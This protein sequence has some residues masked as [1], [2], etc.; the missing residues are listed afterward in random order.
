MI[1]KIDMGSEP[2]WKEKLDGFVRRGQKLAV[3]V[4]DD[5]SRGPHLVTLL[6]AAGMG[7]LGGMA[8][9]IGKQKTEDRPVSDAADQLLVSALVMA[10]VSVPQPHIGGAIVFIMEIMAEAF[11]QFEKIR[12]YPPD[13]VLDPVVVRAVRETIAEG[14]EMADNMMGKLLEF[15]KPQSPPN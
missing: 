7:A 14:A 6:C 1:E 10:N 8:G 3:T 12:G 4:A 2:G 9:V 13:R 15:R 5:E 11:E